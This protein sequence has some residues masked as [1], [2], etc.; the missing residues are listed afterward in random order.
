MSLFYCRINRGVARKCAID[1]PP[2]AERIFV[3]YSLAYLGRSNFGFG[4]EAGRATSLHFTESVN[5][6][7]R[8][9]FSFSRRVA[10][11]VLPFLRLLIDK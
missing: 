6:K 9:P 10:P 4:T 8:K 1:Q 7:T 5:L 11:Q 2:D 3:T